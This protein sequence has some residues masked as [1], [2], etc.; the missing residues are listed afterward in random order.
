MKKGMQIT[1]T[2]LL[3]HQ[4]TLMSLK[5]AAQWASRYLNR[6]VTTSN[7]SYLI[8][9]GRIKNYGNGG[10]PLVSGEELKNYYEEVN[11]EN[12]WRKTLGKDINWRLSFIEYKELERTK[13]VH[14]L[15]LK[16]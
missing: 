2:S 12:H 1:F 8:Q 4:P 5:E 14:R 10:N 16:V 9:Y 11:K 6:E 13:H 15:L 7:I 3:G